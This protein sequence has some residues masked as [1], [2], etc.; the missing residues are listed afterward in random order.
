MDNKAFWK[1]VSN[2]IEAGFT[3]DGLNLLE[4]YG[5]Y[6]TTRQLVFKRFSP[7]EQYGCANGGSTHVIATILSNSKNPTDYVAEE[8][9]D[10]KRELKCAEKQIEII[11]SW[12]KKANCWI[13]STDEFLHNAF[14]DIIAEGGE[15]SVYDNGATL[16]KTIGLDYYILPSLALDRI[17]LHNTYFPETKLTVIG[18]G[19]SSD[20]RFQIIVEQPFIKGHPLSEE[21]IED[22]ITKLGFSIQNKRNWTYSTPKIYLSDIHDENILISDQGNIYVIDCDIRINTPNLKL[23]GIREWTNIVECNFT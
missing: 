11:E 10:F 6:L 4:V 2:I 21:E 3:Q 15:A 16:I 19:K 12:A 5:E 18:F 14:G 17:S 20:S 1:S 22:A 9:S 7:P 8:L 13:E 23:G